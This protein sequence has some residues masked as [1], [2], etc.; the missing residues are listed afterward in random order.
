MEHGDALRERERHVH[1][2]LDEQDGD[3]RIERFEER[4]HR[5]ALGRREPGHGLI[6]QEQ[7]RPSGKREG[8]LE[9]PLIA[10]R[11]MPCARVRQ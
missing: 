5:D 8:N 1:I 9:T 10:I 7:P 6:E 3:S 2:V 4:S 11:E